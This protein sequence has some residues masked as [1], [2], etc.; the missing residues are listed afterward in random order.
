MSYLTEKQVI[1]TIIN[2]LVEN[3]E[4]TN[5]EAVQ[6]DTLRKTIKYLG[7][8]DGTYLVCWYSKA[9]E[10]VM[11]HMNATTGFTYC[12]RTYISDEN[13]EPVMAETFYAAEYVEQEEK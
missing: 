8:R 1:D 12:Y 5:K 7:K 10:R 13:A 11:F 4:K 3:H 9:R 6:E 2:Y